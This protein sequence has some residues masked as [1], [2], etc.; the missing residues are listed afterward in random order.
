MKEKMRASFLSIFLTIL[1]ITFASFSAQSEPADKLSDR[2]TFV[3]DG[4]LSKAVHLPIYEWYTKKL[5][6]DGMVLAIH[7]LTL[8]GKRYEIVARALA[9]EN[10]IGCYYVV[11]P[12]M[13]GFGRTR[14]D[15]TFSQGQD[16]TRKIDYAKSVEDMACIAKY[17][18][19]KYP[20][21]PLY[22][23]GE[24]LGATVALALA[25]KHPELVDGLVLSGRRWPSIH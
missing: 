17:M 4:E 3:Q 16:S 11:A 6:P 24:S 23:I 14:T 18:R 1:L 8:H 10:P 13:R 2:F 7:G 20:G 25:A 9:A 22:V 19:A 21:L 12:D 5:P 15:P